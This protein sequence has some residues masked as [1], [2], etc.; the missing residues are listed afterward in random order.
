MITKIP[1]AY[2]TFSSRQEKRFRD[3][4]QRRRPRY[5]LLGVTYDHEEFQSV[6][7]ATISLRKKNS[8]AITVAGGVLGEAG[9]TARPAWDGGRAGCAVLAG[10]W[11]QVR[12][13]YGTQ[14]A[15]VVMEVTSA[16]AE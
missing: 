7:M 5:G 2:S 3:H 11:H 6:V 4:G 9:G 10:G 1:R 15:D 8:F 14:E 12:E 16:P 13:G